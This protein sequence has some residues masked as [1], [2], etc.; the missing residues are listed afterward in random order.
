MDSLLPSV[1]TLLVLEVL[2][3]APG[4]GYEIAR[5][6]EERSERALRLKEGTLYPLLYRLEHDDLVVGEWRE[7]PNGRRLRVYTLTEAGS[8]RL[9][10][11]RSEWTTRA[12]GVDRI[13]GHREVT[14][15]GPA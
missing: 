13:L 1:P 8:R 3:G 11:S 2:N 7:V 10:Q 5:R 4:H 14:A 6:I 12:R 9:V 15:L